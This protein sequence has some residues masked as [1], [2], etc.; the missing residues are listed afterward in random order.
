MYKSDIYFSYLG[1]FCVLF[2]IISRYRVGGRYNYK[3]LI[4][5]SMYK[6]KKDIFHL[7]NL[8]FL[9]VS[10]PGRTSKRKSINLFSEINLSR[11]ILSRA[12]HKV[13]ISK[14]FFTQINNALVN[15]RK[16]SRKV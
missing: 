2:I 5:K 13:L 7:Q 4:A 8:S 15:P 3:I 6:Q 14:K 10:F 1:N 12:A 11:R 9:Q 16:K